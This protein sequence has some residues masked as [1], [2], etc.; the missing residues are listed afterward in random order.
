[1]LQRIAEPTILAKLKEEP[2]GFD[3]LYEEVKRII[4]SRGTLSDYLKKLQDENKIQRG[5]D[6][7]YQLTD[8]G[9][10]ELLTIEFIDYITNTHQISK[11][12]YF[13]VR[14]NREIG[15]PA[16]ILK[17]STSFHVFFKFTPFA[18]HRYGE[19]LIKATG[20]KSEY[21]VLK[22][23][24]PN[25][26]EKLIKQADNDFWK[27]INQWL[28]SR[29]PDIDG[30]NSQTFKKKWKEA[31]PD[32]IKIAFVAT[33][34]TQALFEKIKTTKEGKEGVTIHTHIIPYAKP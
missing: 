25:E 17:S 11:T 16:Y 3:K 18:E 21:R 26:F 31:F 34:D 27:N 19:H 23:C 7:K 9:K 33:I 8:K 28:K 24:P 29:I 4:K 30:M 10:A 5:T 14:G 2:K 12:D 32:S 22:E 15:E 6:R 1:M 13:P 20:E